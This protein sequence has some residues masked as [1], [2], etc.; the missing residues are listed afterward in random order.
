MN[1]RR[2]GWRGGE[3]IVWRMVVS[4]W[5]AVAV[6]AVAEPAVALVAQCS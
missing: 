2:E 4:C 1:K 6:A 3:L 5:W